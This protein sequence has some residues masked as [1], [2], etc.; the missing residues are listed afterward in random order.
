MAPPEVAREYG[1]AL[2]AERAAALA[3]IAASWRRMTDDFDAS[4]SMV[5]PQVVRTAQAAQVEIGQLADTRMPQLIAAT[6][7]KAA[8]PEYEVNVG[9]WINA[10][11]DGRTLDTLTDGAVIHAKQRV[12]AG[13]SPL[14]AR[15]AAGEWLLLAVGTALSDTHRGIEQMHGHARRVG[16]YVRM[17]NPPS[18]GRCIILAGKIY[19]GRQAFERHPGC[20]CIHV[21]AAENVAG[22]IRTDPGEYLNSLDDD[23]LA[24]ALGSKANAQAFRDGADHSQIINA[25]RRAGSV[26]KAQMYG[27]NI[28]FTFEGTSRRGWGHRAIQQR[29]GAARP[30]RVNPARIMPS[31]IYER[32]T[33]RDDAI[34]LLRTY[35]WIF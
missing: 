5:R 34:R 13:A 33:D 19:R 23:K 28:K 18:C 29:H 16:G 20:D 15:Q 27:T 2:A 10:T 22:D 17:L 8:S 11:G 7:P 4:W 1:Q 30:G 3:A 26:Q 35:G 9:A 21:P 6:A 12:G 32:A 31:T 14:A 24:R 25:Y